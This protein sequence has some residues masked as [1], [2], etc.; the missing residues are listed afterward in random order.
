MSNYDTTEQYD[1]VVCGGG[2]AGFC[3]ALAAA[4]H[5]AKTALIHNRPVLGG[6]SSS[7]VRVIARGAASYHAYARESGILQELEAEERHINHQEVFESG[8]ANSVWDMTMYDMA[9]H[10]PN[11]ALK[12]NTI[13]ENVERDGAHITGVIAHTPS[14]ERRTLINGSVFIDCTGDG[15]VAMNAGCQ[16]RRGEE[17][18]SEFNE[19]H[20]PESASPWTMGNSLLFKTV[21]VGHPA[22]FT[23]P[24]WAVT[25]DD[26]KF[27][28]E[29]GRFLYDTKGGFWW[30]ELGKPWD[31]IKDNEILRHELTRRVYGVWDWMKNKDPRFIGKTRNLALDW[32]GQVP[33]MRESRRFEGL[34]MLTE[35]D[36]KANTVYPDEIAYGGWNIDL[37]TV[38]GML[39][40]S[41]E[42]TA[43]AGYKDGG[44]VS[45]AVYVGPFGIPL[46]MLIARDVDNLFLGGRIVSATHVALG[47]VRV[48]GTTAVMGQAAGT[49]AAYAANHHTPVHELPE[50]GIQIIQQQLLRDGC[51]LPNIP[52]R[53]EKDLARAATV[54]ASS[55]AAHSHALPEDTWVSG[56]LRGFS[57][58]LRNRD[59]DDPVTTIR[60]QWIPVATGKRAVGVDTIAV[61][62]RNDCDK[63]V[64]TTLKLNAVN[65]IWDYRLDTGRTLGEREFTIQPG[66]HELTWNVGISTFE[67]AFDLDGYGSYLRLDMSPDP[68]GN[69]YWVRSGRLVPGAVSAY[70]TS[71]G[72]LRRY[73]E[74]VTLAHTVTPPQPAYDPMQ[75]IS[76]IARPQKTVSEWRSDPD[77]P[78]PA[79]IQLDWDRPQAIHELQVTFPGNL[80]NEYGSAPAFWS[81]PQTPGDYTIQ[82]WDG[83]KF[84]NIATITGNYQQRR[85][86]KLAQPVETNRIRLTISAT[87]GDPSAAVYEIRAY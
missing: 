86:H 32:I 42:P 11:L 31:V 82:A 3:A 39:A 21:D 70:A 40:D 53:D 28:D 52:N 45:A 69:L 33:G 81:D 13:A 83:T 10:E 85:I 17:A 55:Q 47:S 50:N 41:S 87:N 64:K 24:D 6:C 29:Q 20:A 30:I 73:K 59:D 77:K 43:A 67:L 27:F 61:R 80:L 54:T 23:P 66:E 57:A 56:G 36:V 37:H 7:E 34:M 58:G 35:N 84:V 2:L 60:S 4:R 46:R 79:W 26:P 5:G 68:S 63:P 71:Q 51:F 75:V 38:G 65:D 16:W 78:L 44:E 15:I 1:V 8:W 22:P 12:L 72:S 48:M 19:T 62:V 49:A 74:G 18:R 25:F 76:G 9:Q 14:E